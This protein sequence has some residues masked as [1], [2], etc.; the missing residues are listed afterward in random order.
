[1]NTF[2]PIWI[3][4]GPF[5]GLLILSFSFKGPSA[6]GGTLPRLPPRGND[7]P[8]R[9]PGKSVDPSAPLLDP[10]HPSMPRRPI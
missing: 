10:M 3:I 2:L 9:S 4:G 1:M 5:I 8:G 6:M 7:L